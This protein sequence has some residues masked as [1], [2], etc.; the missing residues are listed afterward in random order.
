MSGPGQR[1]KE[2]DAS[3][4]VR[5][6]VNIVGDEVD[7]VVPSDRLIDQISDS[8]A[9]EVMQSLRRA[10]QERHLRALRCCCPP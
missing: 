1:S 6:L 7:N 8:G 9:R 4:P 2:I 3:G 5:P 10:S